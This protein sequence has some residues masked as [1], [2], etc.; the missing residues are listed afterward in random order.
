M[1]ISSAVKTGKPTNI[2]LALSISLAILLYLVF[3]F[4]NLSISRHPLIYLSITSFPLM[5]ASPILILIPILI[6]LRSKP[7][8]ILIHNSRVMLGALISII[9]KGEAGEEE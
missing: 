5:L 1:F 7:G 9:V 6:I 8:R 2:A 4:L 3:K